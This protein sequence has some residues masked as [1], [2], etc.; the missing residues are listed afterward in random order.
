M[1]LTKE[2]I[3]KNDINDVPGTMRSW[4][5]WCLFFMYNHRDDEYFTHYHDLARYIHSLGGKFS[6]FTLF[7]Y[8]PDVDD[9]FLNLIKEDHFQSE[10]SY[11]QAM[12]SLE[13]LI[14]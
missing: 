6:Y 11:S 4:L 2:N 12:I 5:D 1:W 8:L 13:D 9:D 10:D 7:F 3:D 14:Q